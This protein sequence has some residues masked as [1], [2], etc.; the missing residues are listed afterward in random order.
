MQSES[1]LK[2]IYHQYVDEVAGEQDKIKIIESNKRVKVLLESYKEKVRDRN[3]S[4]LEDLIL[5]SF[6]SLMRKETLVEDIKI[7]R[8]NFNLR[9]F[10]SEKN[11]IP[12]DRLS[13]GERQILAISMLWALAKASGRPLPA[14]IDTPLGRLDS[15]HRKHLVDRYFPNASHQVILLSTDEE[16]DEKFF[17]DIESR[18]GLSYELYHNNET[19][20]TSVREGYFWKESEK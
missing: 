9:L 12:T 15:T 10:G 6:Q 3:L 8:D 13:A 11:E 5:E 16:I 20:S 14:V 19:Q 4:R 1:E 18:L 17:N 7:D 2:S